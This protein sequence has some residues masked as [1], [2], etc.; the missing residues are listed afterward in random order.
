MFAIPRGTPG[1]LG[2]SLG[3]AANIIRCEEGESIVERS[4]EYD[5]T[6]EGLTADA[7]GE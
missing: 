6:A 3:T 5:A 2:A 7:D 4:A 1:C